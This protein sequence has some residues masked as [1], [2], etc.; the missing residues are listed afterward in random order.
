MF[1][2]GLPPSAAARRTHP[3]PPKGLN[4]VPRMPPRDGGTQQRSVLM[5]R[6]SKQPEKGVWPTFG[7]SHFQPPDANLMPSSA[8]DGASL[9]TPPKR[10]PYGTQL[11]RPVF[12]VLVVYY[13]RP[14]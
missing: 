14:Q 12:P 13:E 3:L 7:T 1:D 5:Q 8:V 4:A 6:Y 9:L 2:S 11:L 10:K